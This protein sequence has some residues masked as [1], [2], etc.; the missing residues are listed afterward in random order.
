MSGGDSEMD[1]KFVIVPWEIRKV[2]IDSKIRKIDYWTL[3]K[4]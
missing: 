3:T 1:E 4:S 2:I